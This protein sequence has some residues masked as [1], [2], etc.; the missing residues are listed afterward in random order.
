[1]E[2][3][4]GGRKGKADEGWR[5]MTVSSV[6]TVNVT[7]QHVWGM[8]PRYVTKHSLFWMFL[9][10]YFWK[11]FIFKSVD[12][13]EGCWASIMG[14]GLIY[15][16]EVLN[17]T[18]VWPPPSKRNFCQHTRTADFGL[19][20]L[21]IHMSQFLKIQL[22]LCLYIHILFTLFHWRIGYKEEGLEPREQKTAALSIWVLTSL[23][24]LS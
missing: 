18:Q 10:G 15:S 11:R 14:A 24:A 20:S 19:A 1:M 13:E 5:R 22:F 2:G 6:V 23:R 3:G 17:I 12:S 8:V 9:W 7:R 4:H 16:V 21:H